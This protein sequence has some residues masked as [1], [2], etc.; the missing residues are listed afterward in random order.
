MKSIFK[1]YIFKLVILSLAIIFISFGANANETIYKCESKWKNDSI[2]IKVEL[3]E[4]IKWLSVRQSGKWYTKCLGDPSAD[5]FKCE[6][7]HVKGTYFEFDE[8]TKELST[9]TAKGRV[10]IPCKVIKIP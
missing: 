7:Q 10:M 5:F 1:L 3:H 9:Q 8:F 6:S 2:W 4:G